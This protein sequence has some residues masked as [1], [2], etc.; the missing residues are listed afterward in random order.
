[1]RFWNKKDGTM[2]VVKPGGIFQIGD[3][4]PCINIDGVMHLILIPT[5]CHSQTI[6]F[7]MDCFEDHEYGSI[8]KYYGLGAAEENA[9]FVKEV[10]V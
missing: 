7:G 10:V 6:F 2:I 4:Y 8:Y 5:D 9:V 1:M 3:V